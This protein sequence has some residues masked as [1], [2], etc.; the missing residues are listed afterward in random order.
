VTHQVNADRVDAVKARQ[1]RYAPK[2]KKYPELPAQTPNQT[3]QIDM[4]GLC[5][6][7]GPIKFYSLHAVDT[8]INRCV[9]AL[10]DGSPT[11]PTSSGQASGTPIQTAH[12]SG[13]DGTG[14]RIGTIGVTLTGDGPHTLYIV[15]DSGN[16]ITELSKTNNTAWWKR[17]SNL[18]L[19]KQTGRS[20]G[21]G[22]P[23]KMRRS[24][25]EP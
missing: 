23:R 13:I 7:A 12:I 19:L 1:R 16:A 21:S 4:V 9:S 20:P 6:L 22:T 14:V 24:R 2:G 25:P 3:Q 10:Y 15:A 5:Y 8:A 17:T 18:H 11:S